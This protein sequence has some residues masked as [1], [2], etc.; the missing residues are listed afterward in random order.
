[1]DRSG[2]SNSVSR[3]NMIVKAL[4]RSA[5]NFLRAVNLYSTYEQRVYP[6]YKRN[7]Y[8]PGEKFYYWL[9]YRNHPVILKCA[10]HEVRVRLNSDNTRRFSGIFVKHE[11]PMLEFILSHVK[12]GDCIWDVGANRGMFSM[13]FS[14][15][16]GPEG[17]VY[18][19][20]PEAR[21][22]RDLEANIRLNEA[23]NTSP[24]RIAL[25]RTD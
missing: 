14:K 23:A 17:R 19:F 3:T 20:E 8:S 13:F 2:Q 21:I 15:H 22:F 16:V 9:R 10:G 1:M 25:G 6:F 11:G 18:S 24:M 5:G 7:I 12:S 4:R